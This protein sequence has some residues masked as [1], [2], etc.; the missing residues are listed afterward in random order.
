MKVRRTRRTRNE[1]EEFVVHCSGFGVCRKNG[2]RRQNTGDR[3]RAESLIHSQPF[4]FL[5]TLF[6]P[7]LV[8]GDGDSC[9]ASCG[10]TGGIGG[11][12]GNGVNSA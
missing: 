11:L 7:A 2:D 1:Y 3:R 9:A 12:I 6:E 10:I 5:A 8:V 4:C